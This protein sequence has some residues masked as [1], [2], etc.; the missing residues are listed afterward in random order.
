MTKKFKDTNDP[1]P[2]YLLNNMEKPSFFI[3]IMIRIGMKLY[4]WGI[5]KGWSYDPINNK[6]HFHWK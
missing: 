3:Y 6:Y 1:L 5:I 4:K 2:D